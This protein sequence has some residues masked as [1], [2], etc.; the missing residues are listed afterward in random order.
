MPTGSCSR[1]VYQNVDPISGERWNFHKPVYRSESKAWISKPHNILQGTRGP[2]P[3]STVF[4][5][6]TVK[7][8]IK[9]FFFVLREVK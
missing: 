5:I 8:I 3:L 1:E 7:K 6:I 2:K 9:K 4:I